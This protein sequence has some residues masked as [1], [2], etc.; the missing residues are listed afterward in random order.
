MENN[1]NNNNN[2]SNPLV[3]GQWQQQTKKCLHYATYRQ[4]FNKGEWYFWGTAEALPWPRR[5][6]LNYHR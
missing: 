5:F 6:Q 3:L 4:T 2:S 1:N